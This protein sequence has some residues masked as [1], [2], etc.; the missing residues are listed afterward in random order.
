MLLKVAFCIHI[1]M[2]TDPTC[3]S[4]TDPLWKFSHAA[5]TPHQIAA[6]RHIVKQLRE[7]DS[8]VP[9]QLSVD[10]LISTYLDTL[11]RHPLKRALARYD[12]QSSST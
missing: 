3:S 10:I 7:G 5:D 9:T 8:T 11:P 1:N 6:L 12:A 4:L 2:F